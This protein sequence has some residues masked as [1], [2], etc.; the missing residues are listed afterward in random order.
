MKCDNCSYYQ[1]D[2]SGTE[3]GY[4]TACKSRKLSRYEKQE[5]MNEEKD[6]EEFEKI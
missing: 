4:Y 1:P 6:C 2:M 3:D 5:I